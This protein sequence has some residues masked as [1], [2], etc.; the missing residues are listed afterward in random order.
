MADSW[1][2]APG[3]SSVSGPDCMVVTMIGIKTPISMIGEA[4]PT[5]LRVALR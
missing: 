4:F 5:T 1:Y 3:V 2:C